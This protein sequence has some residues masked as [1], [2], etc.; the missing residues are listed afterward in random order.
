M[1]NIF[2]PIL[3]CCS[4]TVLDAQDFNNYQILTA[5][6]K[7]PKDYITSSTV[8]YKTQ[9]SK[10]EQVSKSKKEKKTRAAFALE[11]N[12]VLDDMLQSG[13]VT[14]NDEVSDYLNQ[15]AAQLTEIDAMKVHVYTLR[16][17][18][19]NAFATPRGDIFVTL[20]L[21]SQL[22]NEAQLAFI[23]AHELTHV[24]K[25]HSMELYLTAAG[26][27]K[28]SK[29]NKVMRNASFDT[30]MLAKCRYSKALETE[31]DKDGMERF[32]KT[33]YNTQ[34]LMQVYDVL[35]YA[36]LPF[37]EMPFDLNLFE[38]K[39]YKLPSN[40]I[41]SK[42][43]PIST[44]EKTLE[45][46]EE[47]STHPSIPARREH[48]KTVLK[49]LTDTL[50]K[51]NYLVSEGTFKKVRQIARYELPML[52]I[53]N[54]QI[55]KSI[56]TTFLLLKQNPASAYLQKCMAK[57]L[58]YHA[59]YKNQDEYVYDSHYK[60]VEGESQAVHY[61][62]EKL[63][64]KDLTVLATRYAWL[65]H[66]KFPH[67]AEVTA[68]SK[69]MLVEMGKYF[70]SLN[71]FKTPSL[72]V[73][74]VPIAPKDSVKGTKYDKIKAVKDS[75]SSSN[76]YAFAEFL[77]DSAF[78]TAFANGRDAYKQRERRLSYYESPEGKRGQMQY[79]KATKKNGLK[80]GI[81]KVV[82]V[83][84]FYFKLD[85]RKGNSVQYI[86][87]E[88]GQ[89]HQRKLIETAA[90]AAN[91][92]TVLLD[93]TQLKESQIDAFNDIRF[94]NEYF[95]EQNKLSGLSPTLGSQQNQMDSIAQKYGTDYFLWTGTISLREL[96]RTP[97]KAVFASLILPPAFPFLLADYCMP[98]YNM[99]HYAIL[100][101][102]R[103]GRNQTIKSDFFEDKDADDL[104]KSQ[105]YDTF[106]QI[107]VAENQ[108][109]MAKKKQK[110][111]DIEID[112]S[113]D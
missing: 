41:L 42:I 9:I 23:L 55:A 111:A 34:T 72:T 103:T 78:T 37:E 110:V 31:A 58:Y 108:S 36:N 15:V 98:N 107:K 91:L 90:K 94:L 32:L 16:S 2:F 82:I 60:S 80:L 24:K 100:Y 109:H 71:R 33:K 52:Y 47:R 66:Q 63:Q 50:G 39:D 93:V 29:N 88:A 95:S 4:G 5:K 89:V 105:L 70:K 11:S 57:A 30:K 14:F 69:D 74:T 38:S 64:A 53:Q 17:A 101:D 97:L 65:L 6:G 85:A 76:E 75:S 68:I 21:L 25:E 113:E 1:K 13:L 112:K 48:L 104:M 45:E 40:V 102:V 106:L 96:P 46:E 18:A 35:Q 92:Q 67:D 77:K 62:A 10:I 59:K 26:V 44:E 49:T 28:S 87:T 12:F 83:N 51:N 7:I 84:P 54:K 79:E 8:K 3:L 19:V 22:K 27:G 61:L 99:M 81:P 73:A 56:Y 20:G 43:N 86:A